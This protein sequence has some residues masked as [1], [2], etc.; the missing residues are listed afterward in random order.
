MAEL[1]KDQDNEFE[2][3]NKFNANEYKEERKKMENK[4]KRN[5]GLG[6]G[7]LLIVVV[8]VLFL[9]SIFTVPAGR[10]GVVTRWGAV[11]RVAYPGLGFKIPFAESVKKM[12]V[13]T[14][15]NQVDAAAASRDLQVVTAIIAVNYHLDGAYATNVYQQI[16]MNYDEVLVDPAVQNTFKAITARFTAEE[17]I[18]K[19]AEVSV[20]AQKALGEQMLNYHIIVENFNIINFDFSPEY[21]A[22]I[23]AKQVAQQQVETAKQ[24]LAKAQIEAQTVTAQAQGQA[25]AQKALRDTGALTPE[26]LQYMFL[27]KWNGILPQVTGGAS[28]VFDVQG[29]LNKSNP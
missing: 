29:Y 20:L 18:T 6:C 24:L 26:Y 15:K 7:G 2:R 10:V 28:P 4:T 16:G 27:Q 19:R 17:L 12:D 21:N 25:D 8:F 3:I 9:M 23:E 11:N 22:A 14:I 5:I 13:R 1:W